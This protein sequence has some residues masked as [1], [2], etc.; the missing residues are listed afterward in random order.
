M[1]RAL[2]VLEKNIYFFSTHLYSTIIHTVC[3]IFMTP[4][5]IYMLN[6][7]FHQSLIKFSFVFNKSFIFIAKYQDAVK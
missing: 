1:S 6:Y 5:D 2:R 3:F 7:I 4:Q